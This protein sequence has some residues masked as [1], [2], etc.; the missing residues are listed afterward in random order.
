MTHSE[1]ISKV[2]H[3]LGIITNHIAT[4]QFATIK[5]QVTDVCMIQKNTK[6]NETWMEIGSK[7]A[8]TIFGQF[9]SM[10][11]FPK[12]FGSVKYI[13]MWARNTFQK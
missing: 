3:I 12:K 1:P 10:K 2:L 5:S 6:K 8:A 7:C 13:N 4:S 11:I 9:G